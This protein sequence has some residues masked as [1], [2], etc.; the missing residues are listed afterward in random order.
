MKARLDPGDMSDEGV[1]CQHAQELLVR[2]LAI[3]AFVQVITSVGSDK[4]CLSTNPFN[5]S[6]SLILT[7]RCAHPSRLGTDLFCEGH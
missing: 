2:N 7:H 6:S 1:A 5:P 3:L 4:Q